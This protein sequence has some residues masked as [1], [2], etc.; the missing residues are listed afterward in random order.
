VKARAVGCLHNISSDVDA[1]R[2]IR[3]KGG[4]KWLIKLLRSSQ[5]SVCGSAAGAL[6]NVSREVA[7]RMIIKESD[8][9][10]SLINLLTSSE[11][12]TQVELS[13]TSLHQN[14]LQVKFILLRKGSI[15]P[16]ATNSSLSKVIT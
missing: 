8:A 14:L 13:P 12:Q 6:Q 16:L 9:I 7:S 1:I 11:V 2:T 10:S 4:I 3:R 15:N 5:P